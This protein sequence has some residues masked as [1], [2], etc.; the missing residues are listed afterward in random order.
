MEIILIRHGKPASANNPIVDACEY[1]QWIKRY[2][3]SNVA[4]DSRPEKINNDFKSFYTLSSDLNR[5]I[6]SAN[7]YL[8]NTPKVIDNLYREMEIPRYKFPFKL[9]AWHWVYFSRLLWILG[10]RGKFES[11][12]EAKHRANK[13]A[14]NLI[15]IAKVHD[16]VILFGHGYMNLYIRKSLIKKGWILNAKNNAYWGITHLKTA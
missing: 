11:F 12:K 1:T 10:L 9:R 6:H 14:D 16:Q 7:I 4:Q 3:T 2:N 15:E 5:A 13:A 8:E